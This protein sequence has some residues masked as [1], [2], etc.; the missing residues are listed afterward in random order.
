MDEFSIKLSLLLDITSKKNN[1]LTT[2]LNL[3]ENQNC[4]AVG[5]LDESS[6]NLFMQLAKEKQK[7]I[8]EVYNMDTVFSRTYDSV[9]DSFN[10]PVLTDEDRDK[11]VRL[12]NMIDEVLKKSDKICSIESDNNTLLENKKLEVQKINVPKGDKNRVLEHYKNQ[13]TNYNKIK[14][15]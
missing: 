7:A 14:L 8:D 11:L 10:N 13:N 1:L 9:K 4:I 2:V 15:N 6:R 12:Q 5:T 3:T